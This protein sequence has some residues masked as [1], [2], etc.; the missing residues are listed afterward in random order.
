MDLL[1]LGCFAA[2]RQCQRHT[3][4]SEC[5]G[6]QRTVVPRAWLSQHHLDA[7]R[8][9]TGLH[10]ATRLPAQCDLA[11]VS[12]LAHALVVVPHT[13]W[14]SSREPTS[15]VSKRVVSVPFTRA[16]M[17]LSAPSCLA[18]ESQCLHL[19]WMS[20]LVPVSARHPPAWHRRV[21][22]RTLHKTKRADSLCG[23]ERA[24]CALKPAKNRH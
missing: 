20:S 11:R 10:P 1:V 6:S 16:L 15:I 12:S 13:S 7:F 18:V 9:L 24:A 22:S 2:D 23:C 19:P 5:Q 17:L 3:Y 21:C 4:G 14:V 8:C